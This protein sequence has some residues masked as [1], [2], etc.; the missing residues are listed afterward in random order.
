MPF[1]SP[2]TAFFLFL[3]F[4]LLLLFPVPASAE[5][6]SYEDLQG[7]FTVTVDC[8]QLQNFSGNSQDQKRIWLFGPLGE[9]HVMEAPEPY[10]TVEVSVLMKTLGRTWNSVRTPHAPK[11]AKVGDADALFQTYHRPEFSSRT[12]VCKFGG[13]TLTARLAV[14]GS[15]K[16]AD[17][18]L[19]AL[20][21]AFLNGFQAV[22]D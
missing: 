15:R 8:A 14:F 9:V 10:R 3:S 13:R 5:D 2:R 21:K 12:Y 20:A 16:E 19:E 22:A 18:K 4:G 11:E 1:E 6:C 7:K 17:Q